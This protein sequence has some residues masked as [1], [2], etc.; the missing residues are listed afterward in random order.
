MG[1]R[2]WGCRAIFSVFS[3]ATPRR[4][5]SNK[6]GVFRIREVWLYS[7]LTVGL[8]PFP[9]LGILHVE[10]SAVIAFVGFYVAGWAGIRDL[11]A[12]K[13][14]VKVLLRQWFFLLIPL[15]GGLLSVLWRPNCGWLDGLQFF[16]LF[17]V[18]STVFAVSLAWAI[19]GH[20]F[21]KP[22]RLY[23]LVSLIPLL[24]GVLFD[25][26]FHPQ[27]YTYN[28]VFG[29][30]LGPIYDE[31]L[32]IRPGLFWFRVLTLLWAVGLWSWGAAK[33]NKFEM[34]PIFG[35]ALLLVVVYLF[36]AEFG[37]NTTHEAIAKDLKGI[38]HTLHF[39]IYYD[40]EVIS[41]ER[42]RIVGKEHEFRYQQLLDTIQVR[43]PQKIR[44]YLYPNSIRKAML[45]GA[46]YTNVAP[47]WLKQPQI[48]VLW[49][50]YD[51]VMPHE[52]AHVFSREFGLPVLRATFS[53]GLIEGFA[54]A[55]E[56]PEGTPDPHEQ[57][58]AILLDP[59][60][61]EWLGKDLASSVADKLSPM[62]FW[63]GRGAVSYTTMGSF[64]RFLMDRYGITKL[65]QVYPWGDFERVYQKNVYELTKEWV[66]FIRQLP[67]D[68]AQ[69][70][71][72][73]T[74]F[75][76]PSLFEQDCPH[77]VPAY[78]R[79]AQAAQA[80]IERKQWLEAEQLSDE[81]I[82]LHPDF[83]PAY[84]IWVNAVLHRTP[85]KV[86]PK[87]KS[88]KY[89]NWL[90]YRQR[91][92]AYALT[93]DT[94]LARQMWNEARLRVPAFSYAIQERL[95]RRADFL[96]HS[97]LL[98]MI[99]T[100]HVNPEILAAQLEMGKTAPV[101]FRVYLA[102]RFA[103]LENWKAA[104]SALEPVVKDSK[105]GIFRDLVTMDFARWLLWSGQDEKAAAI[106][107][108]Y[109]GLSN[110]NPIQKRC[111]DLRH[112]AEWWWKRGGSSAA[113]S[114]KP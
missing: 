87:L 76:R 6:M 106:L 7:V 37:I 17:P 1:K 69:L 12:N 49:S 10:S 50:S 32:A 42:I 4:K 33:R 24:G 46:R 110:P 14:F 16:I 105:Q 88:L 25:L 15:L 78:I 101:W 94:L 71:Y 55:V 72:A 86:I 36:R 35:V 89:A 51:E 43:V 93:G 84:H 63:S 102:D 52:L 104:A 47:V 65:K 54:V 29:G 74:R 103:E 60:T 79:Y 92:D 70:S 22:F 56:P 34:Y 90:T 107:E 2:G 108:G 3:K 81:A 41:E 23:V 96:A 45:T 114:P 57:V 61:A 80:A 97:T 44:S 98:R 48:H 20:S 99:L 100:P 111:I 85:E 64:V 66:E 27:F 68:G 73:R 91:G 53:V 58:A 77:F 40:P 18:I 26:G 75:S 30:V 21:S 62:G 112:Q 31:E 39:E 5:S 38:H 9:L 82:Q 113:F 28:H 19:T 11:Q 67:S 8:W 109:L 83:E 13:S 95:A 59:K